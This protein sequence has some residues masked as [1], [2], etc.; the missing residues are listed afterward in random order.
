ML[1]ASAVKTLIMDNAEEILCASM[2]P[3]DA[4][5]RQA[6]SMS[7]NRVGLMHNDIVVAIIPLYKCRFKTAAGV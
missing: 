1:E 6:W 2:T 7:A 3:E 5:K 4:E